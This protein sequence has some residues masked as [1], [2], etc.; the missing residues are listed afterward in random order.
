VENSLP[1][2]KQIRLPE[3][4]YSLCSVYFLT[5]CTKDRKPVF[6]N[7]DMTCGRP[8]Y[9]LSYAGSIVKAELRRISEVYSCISV[10]RACIMPDHVHLLLRINA[11]AD[12]RPQVAPTVSRIINQFKG[13]VTKKLGEAIWQKS[14]YDHVVRNDEDYLACWQYIENNP[15]KKLD[16]L[17]NA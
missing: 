5:V 10:D 3:F 15:R 8:Q 9:S 11:D 6:W 12:G 1:K 14:F 7:V 13:S 4:D 16:S 2:R 17:Q